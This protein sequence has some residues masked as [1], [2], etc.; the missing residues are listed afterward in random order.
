MWVG[1]QSGF[2]G[3]TAEASLGDHVPWAINIITEGETYRYIGGG[4]AAVNP[5]AN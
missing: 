1:E 5:I 3:T 2:G 4:S